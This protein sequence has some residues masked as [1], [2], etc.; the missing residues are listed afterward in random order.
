MNMKHKK[1]VIIIVGFLSA[2]ISILIASTLTSA[3]YP[4]GQCI[5]TDGGLNYYVKGDATYYRA[6]GYSRQRDICKIGYGYNML[7][8]YC[9]YPNSTPRGRP[10]MCPY[11]CAN[12]A[13]VYGCKDPDNTQNYGDGSEF[14]QTTVSVINSTGTFNVKDVCYSNV[15]LFEQKCNASISGEKFIS[16]QSYYCHKGCINGACIQ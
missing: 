15:N 13:C 14:N 9:P 8:G 2:I 12:D 7:E 1:R 16:S 3:D 5:D 11:G 6:N 10:Y 4:V